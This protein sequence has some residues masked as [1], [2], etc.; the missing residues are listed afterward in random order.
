M[1]DDSRRLVLVGVVLFGAVLAVILWWMR[2]T[3]TAPHLVDVVVVTRVE[4]EAVASDGFRVVPF[5]AKVT[6]AAVLSYR[7]GEGGEVHK[8]CA[9][10]DVEIGGKR[11]SVQPLE[12]WPASGGQLRAHWFTVEPSYFGGLDLSPA[13]AAEK[14]A[15]K[16]FLAADLGNDLTARLTWEAHNDEFLATPPSGNLIDGGP[17][18]LKVRVGIYEDEND[19]IASESVLSPGAEQILG[20]EVPGV[21]LT[22]DLPL[23]LGSNVA[24]FLRLACFTFAKGVWPDGGNDWPL[25]LTPQELVERSLVATP[26]TLAAQGAAGDPLSTAW[27][28]ELAVV[29]RGTSWR[30]A[31]GGRLR[32][33]TDFGPG[34]ALVVGARWA[35]LVSD[36]GDGE[37]GV[38]DAALFGWEEPARLAP[39]AVALPANATDATLMVRR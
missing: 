4:G 25:P 7:R 29:A 14:L 28:A 5:G 8:L 10:P 13:A 21:A 23:P 39:L 38:G 9:F 12:R 20:G 15:F 30:T 19:L 16:D 18:R 26:S 37:L 34:D 35:T 31:A 22:P 24:P 27:G 11:I 36:D 1:D 17:V 3:A 2:R 33:G 32:W 6:A